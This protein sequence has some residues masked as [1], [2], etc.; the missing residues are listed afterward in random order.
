M[1]LIGCKVPYLYTRESNLNPTHW[2]PIGR[3]LTALP[4]VLS[5]SSIL[6][7]PSPQYAYI[8]ARGKFG[9]VQKIISLLY[10]LQKC[11]NCGVSVGG[12]LKT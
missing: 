12:I 7:A 5:P 11:A 2:N 8:P 10:F 6:P 4:P 9:A 1:L 3:S